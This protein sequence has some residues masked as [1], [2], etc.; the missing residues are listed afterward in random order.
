MQATSKPKAARTAMAR[1]IRIGFIS[2]SPR[3]KP[4]PGAAGFGHVRQSL[5]PDPGNGSP[6][7]RHPGLRSLQGQAP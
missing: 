4:R 3:R 7:G 2:K 5:R 6:T 1:R